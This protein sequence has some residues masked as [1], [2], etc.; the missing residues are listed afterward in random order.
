MSMQV[1]WMLSE[2]ISDRIVNSD[3]PIDVVLMDKETYF[4]MCGELADA[5]GSSLLEK[6][7]VTT[8][9]P[10]ESEISGVKIEISDKL[11]GYELI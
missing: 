8:T 6:L 3:V 10:D 7:F 4:R 2:E 11:K 9:I 1:C 5:L